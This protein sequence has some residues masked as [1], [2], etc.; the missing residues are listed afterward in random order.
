MFFFVRFSKKANLKV[1]RLRQLYFYLRLNEKI[2]TYFFIIKIM[3]KYKKCI[4]SQTAHMKT[5]CES[6]IACLARRI[7]DTPA[8]QTQI[9]RCIGPP[10]ERPRDTRPLQK[11]SM[12]FRRNFRYKMCWAVAG[13]DTIP[14]TYTGP[15]Y[16]HF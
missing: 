12:H 2:V 3:E 11:A 7:F 9:H 1:S 4:F 10:A 15:P 14:S 13:A 8:V 6:S 16:S 5:L